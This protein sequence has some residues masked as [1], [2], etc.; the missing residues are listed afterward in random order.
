M[1]TW[2]SSIDQVAFVVY[3]S[4]QRSAFV[5]FDGTGTDS[6]TWFSDTKVINSS[7]TDLTTTSKNYFSIQ[8]DD[9][10]HYTLER[11]FFMNNYYNGCSLDMGWFIA[12]DSY[13]TCT[14]GQTTDYPL[15]LV[16]GS[17]KKST[18]SSMQ[19]ADVFAVFVKYK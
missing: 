5:V 17:D 2:D 9:K 7:W 8:G 3:R 14:W 1:T 13:D 6:Q 16:S 15:F 10:T 4:G 19:T 11:R 12:V 18:L